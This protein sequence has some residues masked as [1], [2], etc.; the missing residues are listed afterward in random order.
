MH[1]F[2]CSDQSVST[3]QVFP[4]DQKDCLH[5]QF[6]NH[7]PAEKHGSCSGKLSVQIYA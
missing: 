3:N 4:F 7:V 2:K 6:V 5:V 1:N